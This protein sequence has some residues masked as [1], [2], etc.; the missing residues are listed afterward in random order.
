MDFGITN[1]GL[2][3]YNKIEGIEIK[4]ITKLFLE[5]NIKLED[6]I[7]PFLELQTTN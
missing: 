4:L 5:I 1:A 6:S 7:L 2:W 3:V